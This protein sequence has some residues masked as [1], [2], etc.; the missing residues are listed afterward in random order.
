MAT[1]STVLAWRM[2]LDRSLAGYSPWGLKESDMTDQLSRAP[3]LSGSFEN[4]CN[5]SRYI[6]SPHI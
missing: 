3:F 5:M 6:S 2:P 1:H 4:Q